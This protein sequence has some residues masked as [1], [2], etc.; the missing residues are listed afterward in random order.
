MPQISNKHK[1]II[2]T[3]VKIQPFVIFAPDG[4]PFLIIYMKNMTPPQQ[5]P[6]KPSFTNKTK[7][8]RCSWQG[9]IINTAK[10]TREY[11][12]NIAAAN[13]SV[14][15]TTDTKIIANII[16][17]K[18]YIKMKNLCLASA[19]VPSNNKLQLSLIN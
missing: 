1:W 7:L 18:Q 3:I 16:F 11:K 15:N 8:W 19:F 10:P 12:V 13:A 5:K 4:S 17:L 9:L 14:L 2:V 6:K